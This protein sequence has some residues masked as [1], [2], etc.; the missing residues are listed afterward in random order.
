MDREVDCG[1]WE[2]VGW[3]LLEKTFGGGKHS[4]INPDQMPVDYCKSVPKQ[5]KFRAEI[6][7]S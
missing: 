6:S 7:I 3:P 5:E 2:K 1:N 4:S